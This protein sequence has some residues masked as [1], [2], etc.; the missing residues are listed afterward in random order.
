M[1]EHI[2]LYVLAAMLALAILL[3]LGSP[4]LEVRAITV[5]GG[6]IMLR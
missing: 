1:N 5:A 6:K 2:I 3:A 4:E